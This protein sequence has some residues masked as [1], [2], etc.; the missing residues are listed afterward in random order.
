VCFHRALD[1]C[2]DPVAAVDL[3]AGWGVHRVLSS[4]HEVRAELVAAVRVG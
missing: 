2:R 1:V 4:G 3:L